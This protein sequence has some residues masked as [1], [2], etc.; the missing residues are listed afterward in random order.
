ML[1]PDKFKLM[2][3]NQARLE[4]SGDLIGR[5]SIRYNSSD[6]PQWTKAC[7]YYLTKLQNLILISVL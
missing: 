4:I 3:Q 6:L 2:R 7:K 1:P 5:V